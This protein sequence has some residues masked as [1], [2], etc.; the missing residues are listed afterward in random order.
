LAGKESELRRTITNLFALSNNLLDLRV[1]RTL[2]LGMTVLG[3][4]G[5]MF[6]EG[7]GVLDALYMTIITMSTVGYGELSP[8]SDAGRIFVM[9]LIIVN[10]AVFAY[11]LAA[12]S[13]YVI[14]GKIFQT[15]H[16]TRMDKTIN[17]LSRHAI[18]CGAGKYGREVI[19]N[20][21]RHHKEVVII[22][23]EEEKIEHLRERY[24][25]LLYV[26]GDATHDDILQNAG[27]DRAASLISAL[28]DDSD[29]LFI[30]L[31]AHQLNA[32]LQIISRAINDR[33]RVKMLKAGASHVVMPEQIGGFYMASLISKPGAVEFFSFITNELSSD[34]GFEEIQYRR[35]KPQF[36]DRP[37]REMDLRHKTGVN[38]IAYRNSDGTYIVNPG[39]ETIISAGGS[40]IALGNDGQLEAL[41]GYL[42][43]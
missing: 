11:V 31:S 29:N 7:Y 13:Y 34:I 10:T 23:I 20:L 41:H 22:D 26:V 17:N 24:P 9:L 28:A 43:K 2:L 42:E 15:I 37:I 14:D 21:Q 16:R 25:E 4:V 27:I 39:P 33:A 30:V 12:F 18:V 32:K 5:F 36:Q 19:E 6:I 8:L 38:I 40:F 3:T 35:L 1:A